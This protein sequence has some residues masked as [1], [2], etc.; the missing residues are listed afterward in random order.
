MAP[1]SA[2]ASIFAATA[3]TFAAPPEFLPPP[4]FDY[5]YLLASICPRFPSVLDLS[6]VV[7]QP[8]MGMERTGTD[9]QGQDAS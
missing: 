8:L 2:A 6:S 5:F 4:L 7:A 1:I 3:P 9:I